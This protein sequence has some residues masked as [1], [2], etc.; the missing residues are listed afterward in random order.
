MKKRNY[1]ILFS[2]IAAF[3]A[4]ENTTIEPDPD[5]LGFQFFPVSINDKCIYEVEEINYRNDGTIDTVHYTIQDELIDSVQNDFKVTIQGYRYKIVNNCTREILNTIEITRNPQIATQKLGNNHEVKLSFP[6]KE[7]LQWNGKPSESES[8]EY[9][10]YKVFQPY[11]I[12]DS[13]F[14]STLHVIQEDNQDSVIAFDKRIE[15]YAANVGLIYKLSSQLEFCNE[16]ECLGL[17]QID[18]GKTVTIQRVL[19]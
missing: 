19:E 16:T 2:F 7:A 14:S 4:C 18:F 15:V 10:L 12:E 5:R 11:E 3:W 6:V 13:I 1:L 9:V 8:D 17:K